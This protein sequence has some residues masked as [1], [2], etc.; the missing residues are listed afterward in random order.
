MRSNERHLQLTVHTRVCRRE[1]FHPFNSLQHPS[2]GIPLDRQLFSTQPQ[3][4]R[5][6]AR[7]WTSTSSI[8][9]ASYPTPR[10]SRNR[11]CCDTSRCGSHAVA[12]VLCADRLRLVV[13]STCSSNADQPQSVSEVSDFGGESFFGLLNR[14]HNAPPGHL[15]ITRIS[16]AECLCAVLRASIVAQTHKS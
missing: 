13:A 5:C 15:A 12:T 14:C 7:V 11:R 4:L 16:R 1:T 10:P 8:L 2:L 6:R 9:S 3:P